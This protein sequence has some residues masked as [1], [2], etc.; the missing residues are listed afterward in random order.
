[1]VNFSVS[2]KLIFTKYQQGLDLSS[3]EYCVQNNSSEVRNDLFKDS[4]IGGKKKLVST[5]SISGCWGVVWFTTWN[6]DRV[7][8]GV[9]SSWGN[10][11]MVEN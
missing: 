6:L 3:G 1:M 2:S 5:F 4:W 9:C 11:S 10:F 8:N 7:V